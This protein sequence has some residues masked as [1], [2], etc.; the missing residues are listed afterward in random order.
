MD[1]RVDESPA[2]T[3]APSP[4]GAPEHRFSY[5]PALD[6]IRALSVL[7][8]IAYHYGY[9]WAKGG[10]LG[11]DA[12]FV[13]SGYLITT[14][15]VLEYRRGR[16]IGLIAFWGRRARRLLPA[17]F[18]VLIFVALY[19]HHYVVPW[20]RAG[21]RNDGIASLFYAA[22]WRFVIDQQ[23]YFTLFSAA[24]P[25]R[26]TWSLAIEE[27]FYI[28]WP[29][30]VLGCLRL[31]KGSTRLL[32]GVCTAG[33]LVSI[34]LMAT[35]YQVGDP[36]RAYYGTDTHAHAL[37]IG[38]LLALVLLAW[39][40]S[41]RWRRIVKVVGPLALV[42]MFVAWW[43]VSDVAS[44]YYHGGSAVFAIVVALVISASMTGGPTR[45]ALAFGPLPW[46]GR[47]SYGLYLWHWPIIVWIVPTRLHVGTTT[48]NLVRL[49]LT[50]A[51][52]TAS[53][54]VVEL[55]IRQGWQRR[56][57]RR[58]IVWIAPI[59]IAV[60]VVAIMASTAGATPPPNYLW[61]SGDPLFCGPPRPQD[62]RAARAEQRRLGPLH[63]PRRVEHQRILLIGDSTACSL[64]IGLSQVGPASGVEVDQGSVF[65]CGIAS[66]EITTTRNEQIT[67]HS[68]RC[69]E[70]V[71]R[72][73]RE[74]L[75]RA[76]P[77]LVLWMSIWEK[78][79]IIQDGKTLVSGTPA[80]DRAMLSRMDDALRRVT[81]G[82]AKVALITVAP[83]APNDAQGTQQTSTAVEDASYLR[84]RSID[85][86]FAKRHPDQ[87][88]V[89]DL[90][91]QLC[92]E[93]PPCP[94]FVHGH[95]PRPDGRHFDPA[96]ATRAS[97]WILRQLAKIE[98]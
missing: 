53:Y 49:G 4:S 74:S 33:A 40:P 42:A 84:L 93:G 24:S 47:L 10:F 83:A 69:P 20:E 38:A 14:L 63:L 1:H 29:L 98:Q 39:T 70:M 26:H 9:H 3:T 57:R 16:G 66:G 94:E 86:R 41:A 7:A 12:F 44:L 35:L 68:E 95:R 61:A 23:S 32:A 30:I 81:R 55:P 67:P 54:Y 92:P 76:R 18:L 59:G 28:V 90:A 52:A 36:S 17:L 13:L 21:I 46:I 77:D 5:Q 6:G 89:I 31:A 62:A 85:L 87:V 91:S 71:D 58:A 56:T 43:Q 72:T 65:G 78:S 27:Q 96:A 75:G 25:L 22:N 79:D 50:F 11:V 80:G 73:L 64:W 97:R 82:G 60:T 45:A 19:T 48:L 37:L 2:P 15:L 51:I 34:L 8:V 88:T